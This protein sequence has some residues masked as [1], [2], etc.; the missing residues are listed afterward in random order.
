MHVPDTL[1]LFLNLHAHLAHYS[2]DFRLIGSS[3]DGDP[4][5][6]PSLV[7]RTLEAMD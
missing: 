3:Q 1:D 4:A 5:S 6:D 2:D 7:L